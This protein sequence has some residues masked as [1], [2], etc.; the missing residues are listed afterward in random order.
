LISLKFLAKVNEEG[1]INKKMFTRHVRF[2][3]HKSLRNNIGINAANII[4][5]PAVVVKRNINSFRAKN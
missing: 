1:E 3:V 4:V 5:H 2:R